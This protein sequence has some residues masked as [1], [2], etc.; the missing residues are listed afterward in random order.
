MVK[1]PRGGRAFGNYDEKADLKMKVIIAGDTKVCEPL[2]STIKGL[3]YNAAISGGIGIC[4]QLLQESEPTLV[5]VDPMLPDMSG[6]ELCQK[7]KMNNWKKYLYVLLLEEAGSDADPKSILERGA[8]DFL[9]KPIRTDELGIRLAQ[10]KRI[11]DYQ[12]TVDDLHKKLLDKD[13]QVYP[14]GALDCLTSIPNQVCFADRISEE[15]RRA[16]RAGQP[17]SLLMLD[18]DLFKTYAENYGALAADECIKTVARTL[19]SNI[20]RSGDFVARYGDQEFIVLLPNTDSLGSL[21][22]AEAIRVAVAIENIP[23]SDG[24]GGHITVS[25]GTATVVPD[26]MMQPGV[27]VAKAQEALVTAKAAGKNAVR[28][29]Q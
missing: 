29:A 23:H 15:W 5:V 8:D 11:L 1:Q 20:S 18:I 7:L 25:V 9:R 17:L 19:A 22:I 6:S 10:G 4:N 24:L 28:Q 26:K 16:S 2:R 12:S 27:M 14:L 21:V 13:Y 3:G